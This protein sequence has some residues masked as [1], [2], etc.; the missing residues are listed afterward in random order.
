MLITIKIRLQG[1]SSRWEFIQGESAMQRK[2]GNANRSLTF[3]YRKKLQKHIMHHK[4]Q[5]QELEQ[6]KKVFHTSSQV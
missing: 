2:Y 5:L 1:L 4:Q 3:S 6:A